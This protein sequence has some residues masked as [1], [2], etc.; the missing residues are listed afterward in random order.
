MPNKF[1]KTPIKGVTEPGETVETPDV[2]TAPSQEGDNLTPNTVGTFKP[3]KQE[4][5]AEV[6]GSGRAG[7]ST[8]SVGGPMG[9]SASY[10]GNDASISG[11][12]AATPTVQGK[13]RGG[14]RYGKKIDQT[15][16]RIN[17]LGSEQVIV[18]VTKA[19]PLSD[20]KR[21]GSNRSSRN[22]QT[23]RTKTKGVVPASELFQRSLDEILHDELVYGQG[24]MVKSLTASYEDVPTKTFKKDA[25]GV[26][27]EQPLGVQGKGDY[28]PRAM[29]FTLDSDGIVTDLYWEVD[30]ITALE[31]SEQILNAS[32]SHA[33]TAANKAELHRRFIDDV[34]GDESKEGWSP[35]ARAI[36]EPTRTVSYLKDLEQD[37][38]NH[39][40]MSARFA[41]LAL[42]YQINRAAKDG[43]H[44]HEPILDAFYSLID[45][46]RDFGTYDD[47][48]Q[49]MLNDK[50]MMKKGSPALLISAFD[51]IP[52]YKT[53][54]DILNFPNSLKQHLFRGL[55]FM[56]NLKANQNL[57]KYIE[58]N[59]TFST[60]D[61]D[62]DGI[63]P[64]YI[65]DTYLI[66]SPFDWNEQLSFEDKEAYDPDLEQGM[67]VDPF[68]YGYN[69]LRARYYTV[70][71]HP[72]LKGIY[73][74]LSRVGPSLV[75]AA[76]HGD[77]RV[78]ISY[79]TTKLS[80]WTFIVLASLADVE[81]TRLTT[82]REVIYFEEKNGK[83]LFSDLLSLKGYPTT[84]AS[85]FTFTDI[86]EP[87]KVGSMHDDA[88]L[89][90]FMPELFWNFDEETRVFDD[91]GNTDYRHVVV[92]WY[93][94][95]ENFVA[96]GTDS[97]VFD[98]YTHVMSWP[99]VRSGQV[100]D[101]L[102]AVTQRDEREV[103]LA[104][105]R[106][107]YPL[108]MVFPYKDFRSYKYEI[109]SDGIPA[110]V[111]NA[112][113]ITYHRLLSTPRE[114]GIRAAL[115]AGYAVPLPDGSTK[116]IDDEYLFDTSFRAK[117]YV[118][119]LNDIANKGNV[120]ENSSVNIDRGSLYN[121]EFFYRRA[122]HQLSDEFD[123]GYSMSV[124]ELFAPK[125]DAEDMT[126]VDGK[127]VFTPFT[128][129]GEGYNQVGVTDE[130]HKVISLHTAFWTRLQ[131]IPFVISPW[132]AVSYPRASG[133]DG[134]KHD[135]F[136]FAYM[137]G[138]VGFEG[139]YFEE[140]HMVR[141][142]KQI[143]EGYVYT[144]DLLVLDTSL[145]K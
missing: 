17:D 143:Q 57:V 78:P 138:L 123:A 20:G 60:P 89:K 24:Q 25:Q 49:D 66:T 104:L 94:S 28:V 101:Q 136:D 110:V 119:N 98:L 90:W 48:I 10:S 80:L 93:F 75:K 145:L 112:S 68:I 114:I 12:L 33:K 41:Q 15:V 36:D 86:G 29:N 65:D 50:D 7:D 137:F 45:G 130:E 39:A 8:S 27:V 77:F 52:K 128:T 64:V 84:S 122:Y 38:G 82:M 44:N 54:G 69:D 133:E 71:H 126:F 76:G 79:S 9:R 92:P 43:N 4:K 109:A 131:L 113:L 26:Y 129:K 88:K 31:S 108:Q 111:Y 105:D 11:S 74:W 18:D 13:S 67:E 32:A 118:G 40:Y 83:E 107:I 59:Q 81:K 37:T 121:Q 34:A 22:Y 135:I 16:R 5:I 85:Q 3:L 62:Y 35:L 58:K 70:A 115:P 116:D 72:L 61:G 97:V 125:A 124:K 102:Y 23:I 73:E 106:M 53:K 51:S 96:N 87:L 63:K 99:K 134:Q 141:M 42:S 127:S 91:I 144:D 142:D 95:E 47:T 100:L 30:E 46:E 117:I 19:S 120:I 14:S 2:V 139:S 103:R 140:D 56:S 55:G 6:L 132:D 21:Q 1:S